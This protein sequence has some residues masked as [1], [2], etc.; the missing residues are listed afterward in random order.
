MFRLLD[1]DVAGARR[2]LVPS[3]RVEMMI[4]ID[5]RYL[6]EIDHAVPAPGNRGTGNRGTVYL[7]LTFLIAI[8]LDAS[9]TYSAT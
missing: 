7:F 6:G 5:A 1:D 3:R 9:C 8:L 2:V 4:L